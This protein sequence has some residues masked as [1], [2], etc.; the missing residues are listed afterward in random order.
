[1][2]NSSF[3]IVGSDGLKTFCHIWKPEDA[4]NA[5]AVIQLVHGS[6]EHIK[7]YDHFASYLVSQGFIV[8]GHDIRGHGESISDLSS[9]AY[10]SDF[11]NG[12]DMC[13]EEIEEVGTHI[14]TNY[15]N[16]KLFLFAHSMGTMLA[17]KLLVRHQNY[18]DGVILSGTGGGR[19]L[20]L[21]LGIK[22]A[23]KSMNK[24]GR[25]YRD[26]KLHKLV[27]GTL[28]NQIKNARTASDFISH[29]D[30][31]VDAYINDPLCGVTATTEYIYEMLKGIRYVNSTK[32]YR[33]TDKNIPIL[34][35][36]GEND[37]VGGTKCNEVKRIHKK[38]VKSGN[39]NSEIKIFTGLRHEI[40]NELSKDE[41]YKYCIDWISDKL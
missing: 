40:I 9:L 13:I 24:N 39:K 10:F 23:K 29:D 30:T 16:K 31:V 35:V 28:N 32:A 12:F 11:D 25:K 18:C 38:F 33:L 7:R 37:P 15:P 22:L 3:T 14:R 27:Y 36:S 17:R 5:K 34:F 26:E 6:I 4:K 2:Y 21:S 20:L 8:Y 1:M 19:P 41:V